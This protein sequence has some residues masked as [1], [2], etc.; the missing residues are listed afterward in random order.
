MRKRKVKV[1][2]E[3]ELDVRFPRDQESVQ[4]SISVGRGVGG[5]ETRPGWL[6]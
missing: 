3:G 4:R 1:E 2:S 6:S 5:E